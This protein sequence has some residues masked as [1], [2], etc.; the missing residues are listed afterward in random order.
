M[1]VEELPEVL[2]DEIIETL[3]HMMLEFPKRTNDWAEVSEVLKERGQLRRVIE[4]FYEVKKETEQREEAKMTDEERRE[5][6]R[7]LAKMAKEKKFYGNIG[8]PENE[9]EWKAKYGDNQNKKDA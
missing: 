2:T 3:V 4:L 7:R 5:N 8:E 6:A 9:A 1:T